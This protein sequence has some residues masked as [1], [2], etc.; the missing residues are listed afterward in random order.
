MPI[1]DS[2]PMVQPCSMTLWPTVTCRPMVSGWPTSA[3]ST[4][5]SWML[6]PSPTVMCSVSP[7]STQPNHTLASAASVT[8]PITSAESATQALGARAAPCH[9]VRHGHR[10]A[11]SG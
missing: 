4:L 9:R 7:R 2:S 11:P 1:S 8:L 3:C 5:R 10:R 6:L